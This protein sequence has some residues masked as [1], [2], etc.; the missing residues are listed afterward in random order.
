MI[1]FQNLSSK[2]FFFLLLK[3]VQ[4][5]PTEFSEESNKSQSCNPI[6]HFQTFS[7]P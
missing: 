7:V 3:N 2:G 6:S 1:Y 4:Y 5:S